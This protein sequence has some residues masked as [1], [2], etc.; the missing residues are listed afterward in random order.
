LAICILRAREATTN[1]ENASDADAEEATKMELF[2]LLLEAYG[3]A[4]RFAKNAVKE[5]AVK[6]NLCADFLSYF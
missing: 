3:D 1:L 2:D 5:D 4:E 6:D